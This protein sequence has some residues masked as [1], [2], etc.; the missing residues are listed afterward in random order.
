MTI[1]PSIFSTPTLGQ[2]HVYHTS[3]MPPRNRS[4][5]HL[6]GWATPDF[7]NRTGKPNNETRTRTEWLGQGHAKLA[8]EIRNIHVLGI[9]GSRLVVSFQGQGRVRVF[10][11]NE[12]SLELLED[13][14]GRSSARF[15]KYVN[16]CK[17]LR[18]A[19]FLPPSLP[20]KVLAMGNTAPSSD[21][22][23]PTLS[24]VHEARV[25]AKVAV[26]G[27]VTDQ[28][29]FQSCTGAPS[30]P[31]HLP[32]GHEAPPMNTMSLPSSTTL[33]GSV[34]LPKDIASAPG[35]LMLPG[36]ASTGAPGSTMLP[37]S[38][39]TA[40]SHTFTKS[41]A[42]SASQRTYLIEDPSCR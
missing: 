8:G 18:F 13:P 12:H 15:G 37:G 40:P 26:S 30:L 42:L 28:Q 24:P 29:K 23:G 36:S 7:S 41:V 35:S 16:N 14:S 6:R 2:G 19:E 39:S 32:R 5:V 10:L 33:P 17:S 27:H 1:L 9:I 22:L 4:A 31:G 38:A 25:L 3:S 11:N 21:Q 20:T 34:I